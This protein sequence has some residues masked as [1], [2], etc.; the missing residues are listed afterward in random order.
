MAVSI[1]SCFSFYVTDSNNAQSPTRDITLIAC[2]GCNGHGTC[3]FTRTTTSATTRGFQV[4]ACDCL[5]AWTG[6][7]T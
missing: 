1:Y 7:Y 6:E 5:P 3:D 2:S 4:A